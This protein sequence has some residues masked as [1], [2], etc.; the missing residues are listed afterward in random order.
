MADVVAQEFV[1][2]IAA[3]RQAGHLAPPPK[4][5]MAAGEPATPVF[6]EAKQA[7]EFV[8]VA[9]RR[10]A[11]LF[12]PTKRTEVVWVDGDRELAVNLATLQVKFADGAIQVLIPVRCDQTGNS[13]VEV[14]FAVGSQNQPSGLYAS[15]YRRPTGP[16]LIVEAW[17]EPL[18]A[19]A[20]Q[21]VLG[22][23]S[24]IAGAVGKDA[25]G[26]VLV[27][28]ELTA[29]ARGVEIV[30]MAR[31]RFSGSTGLK[32]STNVIARKTSTTT[33]ERMTRTKVQPR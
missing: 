24:G 25:R 8:R 7:S 27:P 15:A 21:C 5:P 20:W 1:R 11:G 17:G 13:V 12:R 29:S 23:V 32:R 16:A 22:M 3:Q 28:V 14:V 30:P 26:N 9:A 18:V 10:A 19:F 33:T 6:V 2:F 4:K 31:H